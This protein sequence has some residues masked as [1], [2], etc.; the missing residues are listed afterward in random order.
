MIPYKQLSLA[1]FFADCQNTFDNNKYEFLSILNM[2]VLAFRKRLSNFKW[3]GAF[4]SATISFFNIQNTVI[5]D[6]LFSAIPGG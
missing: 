5:C 6:Y 4:E 2:R 3:K 1:D